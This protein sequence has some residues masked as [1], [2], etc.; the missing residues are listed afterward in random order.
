MSKSSQFWVC[1]NFNCVYFYTSKNIIRFVKLSSSN[2]KTQYSLRL[3]DVMF[4]LLNT[5]Y[6]L[7]RSHSKKNVLLKFLGKKRDGAL[8][9]FVP[10]FDKRNGL[11]VRLT[12][13]YGK[14]TKLV[15]LSEKSAVDA[16]GLF[17][18]T[19]YIAFKW[20]HMQSRGQSWYQQKSSRNP[21]SYRHIAQNV[22]AFCHCVSSVTVV[23]WQKVNQQITTWYFKIKWCH[24]VWK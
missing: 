16:H 20:P 8:N 7:Y 13:F 10:N 9:E 22:R 24:F 18:A 2:K 5:N 23:L 11:L 6:E 14:S 3:N 1:E 21:E 12:I 4:Y 15:Q 17:E 19:E